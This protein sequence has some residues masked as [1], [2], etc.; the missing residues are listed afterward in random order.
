MPVLDGRVGLG[1]GDSGSNESLGGDGSIVIGGGLD[2]LGVGSF[3]VSAGL[4]VSQGLKSSSGDDSIILCLHVSHG[5]RASVRHHQG[6]ESHHGSYSHFTCS[7]S[8]K[9]CNPISA[10][11]EINAILNFLVK[12]EFVGSSLGSDSCKISSFDQASCV[13]FGIGT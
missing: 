2:E 13:E 4:E 6:T 7:S 8:D 5:D 1:S 3:K 9:A 12:C 10:N 11:S